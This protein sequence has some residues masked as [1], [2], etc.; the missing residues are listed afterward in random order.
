MVNS[1][2]SCYVFLLTYVLVGGGGGVHMNNHWQ[3]EQFLI[4][5]NAIINTS[6]G[7][8]EEVCFTYALGKGYRNVKARRN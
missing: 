2:I 1:N 7:K 8:Y 5:I 3:L 4:I 6:G